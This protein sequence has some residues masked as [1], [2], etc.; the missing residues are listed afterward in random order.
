MEEYE[1]A[2]IAFE[3]YCKSDPYRSRKFENLPML[4]KKI[5]ANVADAVIAH[6][7]SAM[8]CDEP[9]DGKQPG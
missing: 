3:A 7:V 8:D 1:M 6:F 2:K 4:Q 5:W 9:D